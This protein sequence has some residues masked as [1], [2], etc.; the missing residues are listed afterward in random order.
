MLLS[1]ERPAP[2]G[3]GRETQRVVAHQGLLSAGDD[4]FAILEN[5]TEA[6]NSRRIDK[7]AAD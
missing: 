7:P 4:L 2:A 6:T 3:V 5:C 1:F